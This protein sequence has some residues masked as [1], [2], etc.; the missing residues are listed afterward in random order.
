MKNNDTAFHSIP[1]CKQIKKSK[2][3][4]PRDL[5]AE[6]VP[7]ATVVTGDGK[8]IKKSVIWDM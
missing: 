8:M 4:V 7:G 5:D 1:D 6:L 2:S 3:P